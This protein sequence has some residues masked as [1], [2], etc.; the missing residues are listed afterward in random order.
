[1]L[2]KGLADSHEIYVVVVLKLEFP[3]HPNLGNIMASKMIS[4]K[5]AIL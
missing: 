4:A 2:Y 3:N 5:T 1:M